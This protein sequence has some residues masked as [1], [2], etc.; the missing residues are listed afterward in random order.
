MIRNRYLFLTL[1][2]VAVSFIVG[3]AYK[4]YSTKDS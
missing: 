2:L 3:I 4:L 1:A